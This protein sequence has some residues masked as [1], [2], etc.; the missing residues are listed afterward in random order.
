ML[1]K[2]RSN[3]RNW[4]I[5]FLFGTITIVFAINFG[6]GFDQ[7][8]QN[9]CSPK[10][11]SAAVVNGEDIPRQIFLM[12]WQSFLA[13]RQGR[14]TGSLIRS[15]D[16]K[17]QMMDLLVDQELLAQMATRYGLVSTTDEVD[18]VLL[19]DPNFQD[20][21]T[22]S[23]SP[24]RF[25]RFAN[26]YGLTTAEYREQVRK[27]LL[28][29][30]MRQMILSGVNVSDREV[31]NAFVLK[32]DKVRLKFVEVFPNAIKL[33]K[34]FGKKTVAAFVKK[35]TKRIAAYYKSNLNRFITKRKVKARH[36]LLTP[37]GF[38]QDGVKA[39]LKDAKAYAKWVKSYTT[40]KV[41]EKLRKEAQSNP[42]K[43]VQLIGK[44]E[45]KL[46]KDDV[47]KALTKQL[48]TIRK[49]A[50]K[51]PKTFAA[52][53]KKHSKGPSG[54]RGGDLGFFGRGQMARPFEVAAF[55]L[56]KPLSISKVV[57]T[58]FGL[59]IIQLEKNQPAKKRTLKTKGVN[60]EIAKALLLR[61]AKVS[62]IKAHFSKM[63]AALKKGKT[64][65]QLVDPYTRKRKKKGK[66][67]TSK[68]A[69]KDNK[70]RKSP[71][72][73]HLRMSK[74]APF[75]RDASFVMGL[76]QSPKVVKAAFT[77]TKKNPY[78]KAPI[79]LKN[80]MVLIQLDK[81]IKPNMKKFKK[82]KTELRNRSLTEKRKNVLQAML[83]K[84]RDAST[85]V[86]NKKLTSYGKNFK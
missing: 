64:L 54:R 73:G 82:E 79:E 8:A 37:K 21:K 27:G 7:L 3:S 72:F 15:L 84:L 74:T 68:P 76:G 40:A 35:E 16:L 5:Y 81:R 63:Q 36:I 4:V 65:K 48:E 11:T 86:T 77:L 25:K 53:A 46:K 67:P 20:P 2:M 17:G 62:Y 22:S 57:R 44:L 69:A 60:E 30:R 13:S 61:D 6:P 24:K 42:L 50:L 80:K 9:G 10:T 38:V 14:L 39:V 12:R 47:F 31:K 41:D 52:L 32:N 51:K 71:L 58:R 28:A 78:T 56:K 45:K 66:K 23:F 29:D 49:Q 70:L 18:K 34:K 59:H 83:E 43:M 55:A 1:D 33:N 19:K 85:I 26:Y 75:T